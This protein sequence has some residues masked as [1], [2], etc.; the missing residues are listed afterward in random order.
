MPRPVNVIAAEV[1]A[2]LREIRRNSSPTPSW[3]NH[4]L[5]YVSAMLE[6]RSFADFYGVDR[7]EQIGLRFL[8]NAQPWRG[9]Q[10]R[11][12]K[13]EIQLAIKEANVPH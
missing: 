9:E 3:L 7:G 1:D 6:L 2:A 4:V 8:S 10:A 5:P 11:R 12:I 13:A